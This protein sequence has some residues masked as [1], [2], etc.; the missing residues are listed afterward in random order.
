MPLAAC[1]CLMCIAQRINQQLLHLDTVYQH[2]FGL[3][4][5]TVFYL[6]TMLKHGPA[7][8]LERFKRKR[9]DF[10]KLIGDE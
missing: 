8:I 9:S 7:E 10:G 5:E 4:I 1:H 6:R 2:P 3:G